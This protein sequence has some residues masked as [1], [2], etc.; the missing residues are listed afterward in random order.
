MEDTDMFRRLMCCMAVLAMVIGVA[1]ASAQ[2]VVV[3]AG[4]GVLEDIE[5]TQLAMGDSAPQFELFGVDF[6][7][8]SL[9]MYEDRKAVVVVFICNHCP[10]CVAYED[11]LVE[12]AN[13]YQ[14][15]GVQFLAINPNP[16]DKVAADAFPQMIERARKKGFPFPYLYDETQKT[17]RAYGPDRTPHVFV[18]GQERTL[19]YK[20]S[21]DNH[22]NAP[23]YLADALEAVLEGKKVE[24]AV[25]REGLG[26]YKVFGCTVKYLTQEERKRKGLKY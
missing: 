6:R 7:Y 2:V 21:V 19:V 8:H 13:K 23:F 24:I 15:K 16:A 18:F 26:E 4:H 20:G 10:V 22:H 3:P 5:I 12:L 14:K 1:S 25:M 9:K 11:T 17:A